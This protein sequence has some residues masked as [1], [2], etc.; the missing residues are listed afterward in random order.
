MTNQ[1]EELENVIIA[2]I[3]ALND[4][5]VMAKEESTE[6]IERSKAISDLAGNY[7]DIQ[8]TKID[9][10]R[11]KIEAVKVMHDTMTGINKV[12]DSVKHF[13]GIEELK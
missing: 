9:T 2:Q 10:Q 5:S 12:D 7:I 1:I 11:L 13:L 3:G 8:K 4:N 6:L